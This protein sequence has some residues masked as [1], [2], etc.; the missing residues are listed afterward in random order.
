[1]LPYG[2][3]KLTAEET[4]R[5]AEIMAGCPVTM[6]HIDHYLHAKGWIDFEFSYGSVQTWPSHYA[7]EVF[8]ME[9]GRVNPDVMTDR[10]SSSRQI[11]ATHPYAFRS[12]EWAD[13]LGVVICSLLATYHMEM[14]ISFLGHFL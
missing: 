4:L 5:M 12:G 11:R 6:K 2:L 7:I 9:D 1:M 13:L 14:A 3:Q 8:Y 10:P